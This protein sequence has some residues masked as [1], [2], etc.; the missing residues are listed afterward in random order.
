M[1]LVSAK[2]QPASKECM[3]P[4][5]KSSS[6]FETQLQEG[7]SKSANTYRNFDLDLFEV[8]EGMESYQKGSEPSSPDPHLPKP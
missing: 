6:L 1:L 4:K 8:I 3:S 5:L 7:I 2:S